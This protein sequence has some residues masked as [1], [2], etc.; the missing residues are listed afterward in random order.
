M[1]GRTRPA[2]EAAV[3]DPLWLAR[4]PRRQQSEHKEKDTDGDYT[5]DQHVGSSSVD[6]RS[7]AQRPYQFSCAPDG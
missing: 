7:T 5:G 4:Q 3:D 6:A 1:T 2:A